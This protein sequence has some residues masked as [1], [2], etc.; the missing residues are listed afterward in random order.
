MRMLKERLSYI[1]MDIKQPAHF[2]YFSH[3]TK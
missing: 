3:K 2:Y 1:L